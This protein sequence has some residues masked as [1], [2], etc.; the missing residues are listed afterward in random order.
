MSS[1]INLVGGR[2][3]GETRLVVTMLALT[4]GQEVV[5]GRGGEGRAVAGLLDGMAA[6]QTAG[7]D[8]GVVVVLSVVARGLCADAPPARAGRVG[9]GGGAGVVDEV[10]DAAYL[11][12]GVLRDLLDVSPRHRGR[13][14][15]A[16]LMSAIL[17]VPFKPCGITC[18]NTVFPSLLGHTPVPWRISTDR[19]TIN[20]INTLDEWT[21]DCSTVRTGSHHLLLDKT[22]VWLGS[23]CTQSLDLMIDTLF[24]GHD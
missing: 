10:A 20:T 14:S 23:R 6:G 21:V 12:P 18:T 8:V 9:G 5:G 11:R 19:G 24:I 4:A 3:G 2:G 16:V 13:A 7:G 17:I 1:G 22:E 15:S